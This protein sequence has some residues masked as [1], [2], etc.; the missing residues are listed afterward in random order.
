MRLDN[1]MLE[2]QPASVLRENADVALVERCCAN[3]RQAF[4]TLVRRYQN[5]VHNFISKMTNDAEDAEDLTQETFVKAYLS[6]G[7]FRGESSVQ[8][9]LYRIA[10]NLCI[11]RSRRRKRQVPT[12][13]S[14]DEPL[15][16]EHE[17]ISREI[18]D[19][20]ADPYRHLARKELRKRVREGLSSLTEKLRAVIVLYDIQGLSYEEIAQV[21][22]C[23]V[24]TVKSRLFNA[25]IELGQRLKSY[26]QS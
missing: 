17:Q 21:L 15:E 12:A 23:P 9:W 14:L 16:D 25:R 22:N 3:D 8:T 13:F 2:T 1:V 26:V 20:A 19:H 7:N 11:D 5:K 24:G 6:L 18:P 10:T 4:E